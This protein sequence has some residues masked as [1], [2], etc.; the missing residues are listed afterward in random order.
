[1]ADT[2][3]QSPEYRIITKYNKPEFYNLSADVP[4][5]IGVFLDIEATGLSFT[6]DKLI[7]TVLTVN[8]FFYYF[9]SKIINLYSFYICIKWSFIFKYS[10]NYMQQ[11]THS[12]NNYNHFG[13]SRITQTLSKIFYYWIK[14]NRYYSRHIK[15]FT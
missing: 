8:N 14:S 2:L 10:V 5:K 9:L 6:E 4:K 12:S 7:D 3:N 15:S 13:L 1:M 11:F